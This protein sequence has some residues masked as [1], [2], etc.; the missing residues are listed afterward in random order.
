MLFLPSFARHSLHA[1]LHKIAGGCFMRASLA[2]T[3]GVKAIKAILERNTASPWFAGMFLDL[4][5]TLKLS[6]H[7]P[8]GLYICNSLTAYDVDG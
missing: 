2:L 5:R 1:N 8:N 3:S 6:S 7:S 4:Y